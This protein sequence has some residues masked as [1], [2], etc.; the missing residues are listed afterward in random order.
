MDEIP[1]GAKQA[2]IIGDGGKSI[3]N[4]GMYKKNFFKGKKLLIVML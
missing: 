3:H 1:E 4:H 2:E